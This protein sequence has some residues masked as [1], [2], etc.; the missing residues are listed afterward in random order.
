VSL[1]T[2]AEGL[3]QHGHVPH[4][5]AGDTQV[6]DAFAAL[7]L[8]SSRVPAGNTGVREARML[9]R[10]L[11]GFGADVV[12]VDRPR[13]LRL[14]AL[15]SLVRRF[16]I[17]NKYNLSRPRPPGDLLT[18]LAYRRVGLTVFVSETSA[19]RALSQARYLRKRPHRVIRE[20]VDAEAFRPDPQAGAEFRAALGTGGADFV[21]AVG[22]LTLDKRYDFL[23]D[24]WARD[25]SLPP[26]VVCGEG[27]QGDRLRARARDFGGKVRFL[28]HLSPEHL[29]GA[30]NAARCFVHAGMVETFG[31]SVLE[32]MACGCPVLGVGS[33]AVPEVIG[34]AGLLVPP[35]DPEKFLAGLRGLLSDEP[36][37]RALGAAA[38]RRVQEQFSLAA[39][40]RAY[41]T[42]IDSVAS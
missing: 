22:S 9:A 34:D 4:M 17:V 2:I 29:R 41:A 11:E 32:A 14:A 10:A 3:R 25:P 26:L 7:G 15:A 30:Y 8:G 1:A 33:G 24:L 37:A 23:L 27:A 39:M 40:R 5:F 28:G 36:R 6:V 16:A 20:A 12:V 42:A 19:R 31:L 21:L 13:D 38:R 35:D 18:R